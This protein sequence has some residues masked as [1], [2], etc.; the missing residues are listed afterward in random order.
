M[1]RT[2]GSQFYLVLLLLAVLPDCARG[3]PCTWGRGDSH[4]L[5]YDFNISFHEQAWCTVQVQMDGEKFLLYD[6][7]SNK[8]ISMNLL[9]EEVKAMDSCKKE[10]RTLTEV[11]NEIKHLSTDVKQEKYPDG[12]PFTLQVRMTCL[13]KADGS[14]S[15]SLEFSL[16]G[17]RFLTFDSETEEYRADNSVG[18]RLKKKWEKDEGLKKFFRKTLKGDC[19]GLYQCSLH[20]K[21][22]LETTAAPITAPAPATTTP[23]IASASPTKTTA[24]LDTWAI[25]LIVSVIVTVLI[26]ICIIGYR[27]RK[28]WQKMLLKS[29][30]ECG[31]VQ[32]VSQLFGCLSTSSCSPVDLQEPQSLQQMQRLAEGREDTADAMLMSCSP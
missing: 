16:G 28:S 19:K 20:W 3:M 2:L 26:I 10:L 22:E 15:G 11:G 4:C 24:P 25:I 29:C 6:C 1:G 12:A 5:H 27:Y 31:L 7:G 30:W 23:T 14:T 17:E 21:K 18:E 13:C 8:V 32:K 9:R